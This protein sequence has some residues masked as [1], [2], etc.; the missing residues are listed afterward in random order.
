MSR[1]SFP[2]IEVGPDESVSQTRLSDNSDIDGN[3]SDIYG[4][5]VA[6]PKDQRPASR[7]FKSQVSRT[8][9]SLSAFFI[10]TADTESEGR[11]FL[12]VSLNA[13]SRN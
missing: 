10:I 5:P 7:V 8:S 3:E 4:N 1:I 6:S 11:K 2:D 9:K 13:Q 12:K